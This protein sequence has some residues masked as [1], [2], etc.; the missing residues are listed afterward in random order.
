MLEIGDGSNCLIIPGV[1]LEMLEEQRKQLLDVPRDGLQVDVCDALEGIQNM[2]DIWSDWQRV[3][4]NTCENL[5][6]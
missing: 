4:K 2:L 3:N 5:R 1:D 6:D